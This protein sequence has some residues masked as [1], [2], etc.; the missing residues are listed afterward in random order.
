MM[1]N[2]N[3]AVLVLIDIQ[4]KLVSAMPKVVCERVIKEVSILLTAS[5]VME[6][7]VLVTEQYPKGLGV[8]LPFLT[9]QIATCEAIEKT[10]FSCTNVPAFMT[11]LEQTGRRQVI[12]TGMETH[13]CVLQ[14]ALSL[15]QQ[16]YDVF[17]VEDAVSSRAKS[18]QTNGLE[19][20]RNA[21]IHIINL[22]SV[23]FELLGDAT[24]PQFKTLAKLIV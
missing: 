20:M 3:D 13:I 14:T 23:L 22:E 10:S 5:N 6:I 11:A 24:H 2:A 12:L 4:Q 16:G 21:G 19:R 1:T 8:T 15:K 9:D 7:P 18:H 17:V